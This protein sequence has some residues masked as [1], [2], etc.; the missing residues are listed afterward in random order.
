VTAQVERTGDWKLTRLQSG[1]AELSGDG[2]FDVSLELK[3]IFRDATRSY[4]LKYSANYDQLQLSAAL[5]N[6]RGGSIAY[7]VDAERM[8]AG[9]L[10]DG[11]A[12]FH[13]DATL[14]FAADGGASLSLDG[15]YHY[16]IDTTTGDVQKM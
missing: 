11:D 6:V 16:A 14:A 5:P 9:T 3:S 2:T 4:A 1:T 15:K 10:R 7:S 13:I 8:A 12:K